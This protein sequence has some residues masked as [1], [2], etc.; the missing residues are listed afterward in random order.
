VT[1]GDDD[2]AGLELAG[3]A[4]LELAGLAGLAL[5]GLAHGGSELLAG[6]ADEA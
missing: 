4:G 5:A 3:L 6:L 1:N 2:S